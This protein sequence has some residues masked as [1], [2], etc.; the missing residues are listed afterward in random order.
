MHSPAQPGNAPATLPPGIPDAIDGLDMAAGLRRMEGDPELYIALLRDFAATERSAADVIADA[1]A[2]NDWVAAARRAH[3]VK[4]L[5]GTFGAFRLQ[6][7]AESLELTLR[8]TRP[9][10][11][12]DAVLQRF[13][14]EL[15]AL[16]AELDAKL[17]PE[18]ELPPT[19][20]QW[21]GSS[22]QQSAPN[23]SRS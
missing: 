19:P 16:M 10:A 11:K 1:L 6:P 17:P 14:A 21:T 13:R 23:C 9:M 15:Q 18:A 20:A 5:A 22:L 3:T 12:V 2:A 7:A 4:G 8:E